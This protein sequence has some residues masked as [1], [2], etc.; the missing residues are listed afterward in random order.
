MVRPT[1]HAP[2]EPR[3]KRLS[4]DAVDAQP[5]EWVDGEL[6][7]ASDTIDGSLLVSPDVTAVLI[8][9][10]RALVEQQAALT[11]SIRALAESVAM[12]AHA[13]VAEG[14]DA[15]TFGSLDG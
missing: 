11:E 7:N 3:P 10:M 13:V 12:F 2:I 5:G 1:Q 14:D 6:V 4:R 8:T 15:A 9:E